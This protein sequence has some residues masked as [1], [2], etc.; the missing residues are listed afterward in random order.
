MRLAGAE[1]FVNKSA[2]LAELLKGDRWG[3]AKNS[4]NG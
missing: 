3:G 4:L 2:S 1:A